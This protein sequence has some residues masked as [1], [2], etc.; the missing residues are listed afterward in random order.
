MRN[1]VIKLHRAADLSGTMK[2]MRLWLDDHR[3]QPHRFTCDHM[4]G[5]HVI[6]VDLS[7]DNKADAFKAQF[8]G[9]EE[10]SGEGTM[11]KVFRWRLM[12]E[13]IRTED[14]G[15]SSTSAKHTLLHAAQ[16]LDRMAKDME[17]WFEKN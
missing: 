9:S 2:A 12:A 13:E 5:W 8:G 16:T 7:E 15:F 10:K 11:S 1:I 6:R 3:C 4:L 17:R 14:D